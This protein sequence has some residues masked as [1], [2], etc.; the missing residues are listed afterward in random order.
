MDEVMQAIFD[1]ITN[2]EPEAQD[3][4]FE[5]IRKYKATRKH[6]SPIVKTLISTVEEAE[7]FVSE[8]N[9]PLP[10]PP[11]APPPLRL[12]IVETGS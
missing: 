6:H 11:P 9:P 2:T 1:C 12:R 4:I 3:Q 5:A 10:T 8:I 7:A